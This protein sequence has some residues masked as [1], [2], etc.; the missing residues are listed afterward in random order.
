MPFAYG[1]PSGFHGQG[2]VYIEMISPIGINLSK[3][4]FKKETFSCCGKHLDLRYQWKYFLSRA[5]H[6]FDENRKEKNQI[7]KG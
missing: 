6:C 3:E 4:I 5:E 1:I 2:Y 7:S